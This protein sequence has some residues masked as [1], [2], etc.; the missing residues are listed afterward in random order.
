MIEKSEFGQLPN[1]QSVESYT[2]TN[3]NGMSIEILTLGAI[4]RSWKTSLHDPIDIVLGFD[5]VEDYLADQGYLGRTVGR[6]A[7][8]IEK[9]QFTLNG[10]A[11]QVS[12][13]LQGN[14]LHGG[15]EGFH[16]RIWQVSH[17]QDTP[18]PAITL[19]I[20]SIDGDQGFPGTLKVAV[21]FTLDDQ[22]CLTI[23]YRAQS[24]KDTVF[25]PTQHSYFNLAGHDSGPVIEHQIT[26]FAGH[27]TPA[28]KEAIPT[29]EIKPV[30]GSVFDLSQPTSFKTAIEDKNPEIM[31]ASGLDHN[32]CIDGFANEQ[33]KML[34]AAVVTEV[35]SGRKLI[36]HTTMPGMQIYT[37]NFIGDSP[38]GKNQTTYGQYHG[39]CVESQFYPNSPNQPNFPSATLKANQ[40]FVSKTSY[41]VL[42]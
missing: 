21:E 38:K 30:K 3:N 18:V 29:G 14:A 24:D 9:G 37:G 22:N 20:T 34:L 36:T 33:D 28:N 8:R 12:T 1:G 39:F 42:Q 10:E 26:A 16:N 27:Y 5:S 23:E 40:E 32:W 6:Y 19:E 13:N 2:M 25:N 35:H 7:N 17:I 41:Q 11:H 4:I 31:A 15:I